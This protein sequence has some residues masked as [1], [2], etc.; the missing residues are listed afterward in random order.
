MNARRLLVSGG[1][2][3]IAATG[4]TGR[5]SAAVAFEATMEPS[6]ISFPAT[7]SLT[8]RLHMTSGDRPERFRVELDPPAWRPDGFRQPGG[9]PLLAGC[10]EQPLTLAG[11]GALE[12]PFCLHGDPPRSPSCSRGGVGPAVGARV[13]LPANSKATL[14]AQ[15][16]TASAPLFR[17]SDPRLSFRIAGERFEAGD[18][19]AGEHVV[20]P[21]EPVVRPPFAVP[22]FLTTRPAAGYL[23][24]FTPIRRGRAIDVAGRTLPSLRGERMVLRA[25]PYTQRGA[26]FRLRTIAPPRQPHRALS[27]PR[28]APEPARRL[29]GVC[30]LPNTAPAACGRQLVRAVVPRPMSMDVAELWARREQRGGR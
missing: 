19:T 14:I 20:R 25:G 3:L 24:A 12:Q 26:R 15:Y 22:I 18:T 27:P 13:L 8:F 10:S 28:V 4:P 30:P 7:K 6:R 29:R 2:A 9:S 17:E 5:A 23:G 21:A 1:L 16:R 11:P